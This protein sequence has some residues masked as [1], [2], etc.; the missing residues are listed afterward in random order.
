MDNIKEKKEELKNAWEECFG[1]KIEDKF[2]SKGIEHFWDDE[3]SV[4]EATDMLTAAGIDLYLES[5]IDEAIRKV[6]ADVHKTHHKDKTIFKVIG[7]GY[8]SI[9]PF[10]TFEDASEFKMRLIQSSLYHG[11]ADSLHVVK[12][13]III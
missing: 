5:V 3:T 6:K 10:D 11:N 8:E 2:N 12:E 7:D 9:V 13:V 1:M 4:E